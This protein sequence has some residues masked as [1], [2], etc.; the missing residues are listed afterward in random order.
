MPETTQDAIE[1][2]DQLMNIEEWRKRSNS[3]GRQINPVT[4]ESNFLWPFDSSARGKRE[5]R[6]SVSEFDSCITAPDS[7][8]GYKRESSHR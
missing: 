1:S 3:M 5:S 4:Y 6:V 7:I 8:H 2:N